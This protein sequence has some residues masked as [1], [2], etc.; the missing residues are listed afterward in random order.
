[1]KSDQPTAEQLGVDDSPRD[2][3]TL[4]TFAVDLQEPASSPESNFLPDPTLSEVRP[5]EADSL[6]E[7]QW[8]TKPMSSDEDIAD[9]Y[10][11]SYAETEEEVKSSVSAPK[12]GVAV[13]EDLAHSHASSD[14]ADQ[15][16]PLRASSSEGSNKLTVS[17]DSKVIESSQSRFLQP[18]EEASVLESGYSGQWSEL[19]AGPRHVSKDLSEDAYSG[20]WSEEGA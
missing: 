1:P 11:A 17:E 12:S 5:D 2:S 18:L 4:L 3:R 19:D 15:R 13:S 20:D 6:A 8:D 16:G 7:Y 9:E 14:H 10:E